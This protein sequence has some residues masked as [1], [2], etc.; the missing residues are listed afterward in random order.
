MRHLALALFLVA[1][2]TPTTSVVEQEAWSVCPPAAICNWRVSDGDAWC[3]KVVCNRPAYCHPTDDLGGGICVQLTAPPVAPGPDTTCAMVCDVDSDCQ[4]I[5][6]PTFRCD[7][8][9]DYSVCVA[10]TRT[11]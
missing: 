11:P 3:T 4:R 10:Q 6:G 1:C 7:F 5:C 2:A 8:R 9:V